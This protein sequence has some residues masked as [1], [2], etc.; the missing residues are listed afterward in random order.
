MKIW[1][2]GEKFCNISLLNGQYQEIK[3]K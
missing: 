2:E 3:N 1:T